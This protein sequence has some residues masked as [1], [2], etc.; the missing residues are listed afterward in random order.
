M[1]AL[2]N[3]VEKRRAALVAVERRLP[4]L[5]AMLHAC[6]ERV[7]ERGVRLILALPNLVATR[8]STLELCGHK[9]V[10]CLRHAVARIHNDAGRTLGSA[11]RCA[12][13]CR[14]A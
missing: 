9:L 13:A 1:L 10:A 3:L 14:T 6:R 7:Q 11:E 5:P 2:P 12:A 4:D 8:R